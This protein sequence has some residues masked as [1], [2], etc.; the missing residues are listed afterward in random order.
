MASQDN[1]RYKTR[2]QDKAP[3]QDTTTHQHQGKGQ[4]TTKDDRQD[5]Q[6]RNGQLHFARSIFFILHFDTNNC[7]FRLL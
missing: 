3:R 2:H 1:T 6:N 4:D 5:A 7:T